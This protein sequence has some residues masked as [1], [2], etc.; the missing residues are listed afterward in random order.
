MGCKVGNSQMC[1]CAV[2]GRLVGLFDS[3]TLRHILSAAAAVINTSQ[4]CLPAPD[5]IA[6][7]SPLFLIKTSLEQHC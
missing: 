1:K 3:S 5:L 7:L 4:L 6:D 2:A